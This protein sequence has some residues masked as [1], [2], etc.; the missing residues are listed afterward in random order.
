MRTETAA[1]MPVP[2]SDI[3]FACICPART[4]SAKLPRSANDDMM[5]ARADVCAICATALI[6]LEQ[7]ATSR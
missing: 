6:A 5:R 3:S 1:P 4:Q 2:A 7:E